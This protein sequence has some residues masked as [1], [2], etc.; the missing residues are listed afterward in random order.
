MRV[1]E[2]EDAIAIE[3]S[4]Q[5]WKGYRTSY[6]LN[7]ECIAPSAPVQSHQPSSGIKHGETCGEDA[8]SPES[9]WTIGTELCVLGFHASAPLGPDESW[10]DVL[11]AL[12]MRI[13]EQFFAFVDG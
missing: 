5:V 2:M 8:T 12:R 6:E 10:Y 7:V 1:A 9:S 13:Q 4:R 11:L 3:C